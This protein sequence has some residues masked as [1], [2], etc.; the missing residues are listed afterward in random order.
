MTTPDRIE[1]KILLRA[2]QQR[3]FQAIADSARFGAWFGAEIE[4]PFVPG[5]RVL[6]RIA[7]T[8]V[9][10]EI[11]EKQRPH[12][13]LRFVIHV[14]R[15]EPETLFAFRWHPFPVDVAVDYAS[16]PTTLVVFELAARPGGTE[17]TI[18]ESGFDQIPLARRAQAFASNDGGWEAQTRLIEKYL[19]LEAG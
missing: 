14:D 2:P 17:L 16:E 6:A 13:G 15:I 5:Q 9:D 18:T 7:P 4:G 8:R 19:A 3:V 11:A 10:P 12:A 1:K